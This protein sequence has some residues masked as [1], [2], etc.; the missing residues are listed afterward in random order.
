[1][2][3]FWDIIKYGLPTATAVGSATWAIR[4]NMTPI[5]SAGVGLV[6]WGAGYILYRAASGVQSA[7]EGLPTASYVPELGVGTASPSIPRMAAES[8]KLWDKQVGAD[9][10][11]E[12]RGKD[13]Q[14]PNQAITIDMPSS[15]PLSA[16]PEVGPTVSPPGAQT[17]GTFTATKTY[18][19]G[20]SFG[21]AGSEGGI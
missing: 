8:G 20:D 9:Y 2:G 17:Q 19:P 4:R 7:V 5:S 12:H 1:M 10:E 16:V 6:G 18:D 21:S 11:P 15:Q 13:G 14:P 3:L